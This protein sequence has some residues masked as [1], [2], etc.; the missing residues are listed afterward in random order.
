M[1]YLPVTRY[2]RCKKYIGANIKCPQCCKTLTV[3]HFSWS[4]LMC[5]HCKKMVDKYD[6][7]IEKN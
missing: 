5:I 2:S 3:Y 6:F 1:K 7:L 4:A